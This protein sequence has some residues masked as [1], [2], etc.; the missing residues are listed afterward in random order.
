[1]AELDGA[2]TK[3]E[4]EELLNKY[5]VFSVDENYALELKSVH[6]I[7]EFREVSAVPETPGYILGVINLRGQIVPVIDL[8]V[9][10]HKPAKLNLPRRCIIV[11]KYQAQLLGLVVDDVL[12]LVAIEEDQISSPPRVNSSY[13][14]VFIKK[15]G[16]SGDS[17][18]L[19]VDE[20]KLVNLEDL[21]FMGEG[22]GETLE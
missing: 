13:E 22:T 20:D 4:N 21:D 10:F 5:L 11:A 18:V 14:H 7:V 17:M 2:Q 19:I 9:R 8:R 1:M 16:V 15:I 12:D 6:E 3:E